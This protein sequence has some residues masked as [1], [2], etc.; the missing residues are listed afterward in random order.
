MRDR[1]R[2][3]PDDASKTPGFYA[4]QLKTPR[5]EKAAL[6]L[7]PCVTICIFQWF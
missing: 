7:D 1:V 5:A 2:G 4:E 6:S 3:H